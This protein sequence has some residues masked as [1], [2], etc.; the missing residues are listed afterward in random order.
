MDRIV[1]KKGRVKKSRPGA[2]KRERERERRR[3]TSRRI[4]GA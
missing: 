2:R 3:K 1:K 4:E